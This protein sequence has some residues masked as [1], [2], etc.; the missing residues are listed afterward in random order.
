MCNLQGWHY[1]HD[2][3][4]K[5]RYEQQLQTKQT[6]RTKRKL[7]TSKGG[8]DGHTNGNN[9]YRND[10]MYARVYQNIIVWYFGLA[11]HAR[12]Q[13]YQILLSLNHTQNHSYL[14]AQTLLHETQLAVEPII[15]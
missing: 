5:L 11:R 14:H 9:I 13:P 6:E 1:G 7:L 3:D 10:F 15:Y 12:E 4:N 2:G 8:T